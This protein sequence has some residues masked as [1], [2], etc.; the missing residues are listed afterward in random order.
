LSA[1]RPQGSA[2]VP[3]APVFGSARTIRGL[4]SWLLRAQGTALGLTYVLAVRTLRLHLHGQQHLRALEAPDPAI[5]AVWHGQTHLLLPIVLRFPASRRLLTILPDDERGI[6][7]AV[8]TR[9]V[10]FEGFPISTDDGSMGGARQLLSLLNRLR[11]GGLLMINPDGPYGPA[12]VAKPGAAY[13]AQRSRAVVL[14]VGSYT[15]TCY[16]LRRW[17]RY[18]LPLPF[19]RVTAVVRPPLRF[20]RG[21]SR[22]QLLDVLSEELTAALVE[23]ER[24]HGLSRRR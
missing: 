5:L 15:H 11:A 23:A 21:E 13:L 19:S 10:G 9:F 20:E 18:A 8:A 14:P 6:T 12:R 22:G 7:L 24:L 3:A 1:L 17:D 2:P 4:T 16:R